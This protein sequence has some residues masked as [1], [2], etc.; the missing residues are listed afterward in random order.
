MGDTFQTIADPDASPQDSARLAQRV[1]EWLVQEGIVLAEPEPG[2][3]L[4][5]RDLSH[6]P[7]P[8][9]HKAVANARWGSPGGVVVHTERRVFYTLGDPGPATVT[10]P[11][12]RKRA[13]VENDLQERFWAACEAWHAT[14]HADLDCPA[15]AAPVPLPAWTWTDD[16]FAFAHLGFEFWN[17]PALSADFRSRTADFL[18]C[19]RTA[20]LMGKI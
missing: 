12:C 10:C 20:F 18:E 15:C 8:H 16:A 3:A 5:E 2:W 6:P 19:H 17:W 13:E 14:G 11:R 4:G 1:V 7:G 9:W